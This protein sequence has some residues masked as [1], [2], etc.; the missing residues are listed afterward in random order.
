MGAA[1][2]G[3]LALTSGLLLAPL[4]LGGRKEPLLAPVGGWLAGS[5]GAEGSEPPGSGR[6]AD[7]GQYDDEYSDEDLLGAGL[8]NGVAIPRL[9]LGLKLP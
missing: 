5:G 3:A 8:P 1:A 6:S 2:P 7:S 4:L 9:N